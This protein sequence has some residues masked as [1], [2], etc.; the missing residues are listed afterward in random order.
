MRRLCKVLATI[1]LA[2][3]IVSASYLAGFGTSMVLFP[4]QPPVTLTE[5]E[6]Q[7]AVFWEA[8]DIVEREFYRR[9][10]LDREEMVYGAIRGVL[11]SLDDPYTAFVDPTRAAI[12]SED[13]RGSFEGIGAVVTM[14]DG[15]LL[16]VEPLKGKPA[17]KAG[18]K[19]GDVILKVDDTEI[20]DMSLIEAIALIRGPRGT[21]V[22]LTIQREGVDEP[23]IVEL[24][25][26]R[27]EIP[28]IEADLLDEGIAYVRLYALNRQASQSLRA[29]LEG[30][31][32]QDPVG[33][34]LDLRSNPGGFL[35]IA[36]EVSSQFI[37]EGLILVER[38]KGG[39]ERRHWA[40]KGGL[41]TDIPLVV[42]VNGATASASEI[43][44]GAI[45]DHGRGV[46]IGERTFGKG[47]VQNVH[48]LS[49]GSSLRVTVSRWLT[50]EGRWIEDQ[51]LIPDIEVELTEEDL[52]GD[53][54][55]QLERAI[56]YLLKGR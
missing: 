20:K 54:D 12:L 31:L 36:V 6:E 11:E 45:Q 10:Q 16:I 33:L 44:A 52:E 43:V 15:Q 14:E 27:I 26:E 56:E 17:E 2:A 37:D 48:D 50:P 40:L 18:L 49:D 32:A 41:A 24:V 35:H 55:P 1:A 51:G 9:E 47:L 21:V 13:M 46:L 29:V 38:G 28:V 3:V 39:A 30:L 53:R 4:T 25:R 5:R 7:F 23:F 8:W 22:R 42:L 19:R 34:I